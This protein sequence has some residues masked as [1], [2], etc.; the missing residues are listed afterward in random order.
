MKKGD[1]A[2]KSERCRMFLC[3][4]LGLGVQVSNIPSGYA[5]G[6]LLHNIC[7]QGDMQIFICPKAAPPARAMPQVIFR[8]SR[9]FQKFSP[10]LRLR[11]NKNFNNHCGTLYCESKPV[12]LL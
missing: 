2:A 3:V 10:R 7:L 4:I 8:K 6:I 9:I 5:P 1:G 12:R 11:E